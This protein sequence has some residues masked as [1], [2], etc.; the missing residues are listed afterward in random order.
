MATVQQVQAAEGKSRCPMFWVVPMV[1]PALPDHLEAARHVI[2]GLARV[3]ADPVQEA[4]AMRAG[5]GAKR[6]RQH[7]R[8]SFRSL[9]AIATD[10]HIG[11]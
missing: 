6:A 7:S 8:N 2:E 9:L 5:A 11:S 4:A 10:T 3:L 1:P